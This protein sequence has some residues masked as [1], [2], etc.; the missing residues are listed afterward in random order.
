ML[1]SLREGG[2]HSSM[3]CE[4]FSD[5]IIG[6]KIEIETDHKPLVSLLSHTSLDRLPP[7]ILRFR[8]RLTRFDSISHV[9]GKCLYTADTLRYPQ[10]IQYL[11]EMRMWKILCNNNTDVWINTQGR[12]N[13]PGQV[14][15]VPESE[16]ALPSST[17]Q[18]SRIA[19]RSQTGTVLHPPDR[20]SNWVYTD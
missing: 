12:E 9:P 3:S 16:L 20:Y 10:Q 15:S 17:T 4:K 19:T 14:T 1:R 18:T 11:K 6:K 13:L 5:Y 8:L 2:T 7:R